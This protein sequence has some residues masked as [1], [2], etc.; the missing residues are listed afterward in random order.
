MKGV[1]I[2]IQCEDDQGRPDDGINI[3][4]KFVEDK[5]ILAV[6]GSWSS[7]VTLAAGPIWAAVQSPVSSMTP[8]WRASLT[9][10]SAGRSIR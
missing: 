3:A 9:V 2:V 6:L 8:W 1:K 4:R 7:S 10:K 5:S